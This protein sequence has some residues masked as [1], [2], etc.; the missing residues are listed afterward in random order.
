M[1]KPNTEYANDINNN[2]DFEIVRK[3]LLGVETKLLQAT[4]LIK[5]TELPPVKQ[6]HLFLLN[7]LIYNVRQIIDFQSSLKYFTIILIWQ[8]IETQSTRL[9]RR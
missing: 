4:L 7:T 5:I 8:R 3:H 6:T 2:I 1:A 9:C